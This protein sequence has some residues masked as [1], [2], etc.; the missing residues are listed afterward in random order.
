[1]KWN[2]IWPY[3][4][5]ILFGITRIIS[6]Y[7]FNSYQM[8]AREMIWPLSAVVALS[9]LIVLMVKWIISKKMRVVAVSSAI[10]ILFFSYGLLVSILEKA[11]PLSIEFKTG[12][13]IGFFAAWL[14]LAF[15]IGR[16]AYR[17][18]S[19]KAISILVVILLGLLIFPYAVIVANAQQANKFEPWTPKSLKTASPIDELPDIYYIILDAYGRQDVL[20]KQ[21]GFDN[22]IFLHDIESRGF[23]IASGSNANYMQTHL[24]IAS[25]LNLDYL[26]ELL[27]KDCHSLSSRIALLKMIENNALSFNL[28]QL[29]YHYVTISTGYLDDPLTQA[30]GYRWRLAAFN[31]FWGILLETTPIDA[32]N[33]IAYSLYRR[34]ILDAFEQL[35]KGN[36]ENQPMFLFAHITIPHHPFVFA[37]DGK[38]INSVRSFSFSEDTTYYGTDSYREIEYRSL[39]I[40]QVQFVNAIIVNSIDAIL[41]RSNKRPIII[42]QGDHGPSLSWQDPKKV[43]LRERFGI[44][45]ACLAPEKVSSALYESVS[46]LNCMRIVMNEYFGSNLELLPDRSY[47]STWT[48]PYRFVD[49]TE[50]VEGQ[51]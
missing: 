40:E 3:F 30:D 39:Y 28:R 32:F 15:L 36:G 12:N 7:S 34:R 17:Q 46:P 35:A 25:S 21:Y 37:K 49:V 48:Q 38:K 26:P 5:P 4:L 20:R 11:I 23:F 1:M 2:E 16:L 14:V 19:E 13:P 41:A 24:S 43:N 6:I 33:Q 18:Y 10:V 8:M 44:L 22:R 31:H 51:W 29:G 27:K 42:L 50:K 9:A 47:Y 45:N